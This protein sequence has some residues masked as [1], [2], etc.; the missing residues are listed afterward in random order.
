MPSLPNFS[1]R[2][3]FYLSTH[4][5]AMEV[6]EKGKRESMLS[7]WTVQES[8]KWMR[9]RTFLDT[10]QANIVTNKTLRPP[11]KPSV[12][13]LL[14]SGSMFLAASQRQVYSFISSPC[15]TWNCSLDQGSPTSRIQC[16]TIWNG[17]DIITTEIK[18][19]VDGVLLQT[20]SGI[21]M[22]F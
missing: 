4:S 3:S 11:T 6:S 5:Q 15:L 18:R 8:D 16:L 7:N 22:S 1:Q 10:S 19:T 21:E 20:F 17:G 12:P 13:W 2:C 14:Y 9:A